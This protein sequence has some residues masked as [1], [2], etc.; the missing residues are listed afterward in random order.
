MVNEKKTKKSSNKNSFLL[1]FKAV[2]EKARKKYKLPDFEYMNREFEIEKICDHETEFLV[3]E[4]RRIMVEKI[5]YYTRLLEIFINPSA[6]PIFVMEMIK[7]IDVKNEKVI[8]DL[9]KKL[10]DITIEVVGLDIEYDEKA[11]LTF[12][13]KIISRWDKIKKELMQL[14]SLIKEANKDSEKKDKK[15]YFG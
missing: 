9:Y 12:I 8:S 14:Y 3:R 5:N 1:Q 15:S 10:T 4:I 6:G 2:Y 7:N 11:E 13:K